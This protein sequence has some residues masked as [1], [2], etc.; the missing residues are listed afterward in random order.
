M[1]DAPDPELAF[2]TFV[3]RHEPGLR[4]ALCAAFGPRRGREAT[5]DALSW[6]WENW[7]RLTT[8]R[9][10]VGYLYRVGHSRAHDELRRSER[11]HRA[12]DTRRP[13]SSDDLDSLDNELPAQLAALSTQQRTA[14]VLVHGYGMTLQETAEIMN[15]SIGSV[16][17][18]C[19][20]A[21][22][23]LRAA[24]ADDALPGAGA[25]HEVRDQPLEK[26][27]GPVRK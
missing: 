23:R 16:R 19:E 2:E 24:L 8:M 21:L 18:H 5:L 12:T 10:P 1:V 3:E 26:P 4:H 14:A 9:N 15:I 22:R 13:S 7:P 11:T 20:R 17:T 25:H 27:D 6:G